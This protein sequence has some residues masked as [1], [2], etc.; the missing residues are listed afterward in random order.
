MLGPYLFPSRV[1]ASVTKQARGLTGTFDDV[2][3]GCF[4]AMRLAMTRRKTPL[5]RL[6]RYFPQRGKIK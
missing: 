5:P 2:P 3:L 4:G 6:R 1:I